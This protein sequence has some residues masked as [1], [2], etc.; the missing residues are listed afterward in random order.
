[1]LVSV[2]THAS[3]PVDVFLDLGVLICAQLYTCVVSPCTSL[4]ISFVCLCKYILSAHVSV[5]M[6]ADECMRC[7][8][9]CLYIFYCLSY[10]VQLSSCCHIYIY[11]QSSVAPCTCLYTVLL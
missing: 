6:Y 11:I 10:N 1:M 2:C 5:H 4:C 7:V 3:I 9:L 8:S